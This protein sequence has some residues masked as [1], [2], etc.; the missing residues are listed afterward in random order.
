MMR[1]DADEFSSALRA[2]FPRLHFVSREHWKT[3][4]D[5]DWWH[6]AWRG[7]REREKAG[8][9]TA[10]VRH[11]MRDPRNETPRYWP[12]LGVAEEREFYG[13]VLPESWVAQW[14]EED[15]F[16]VRRVVNAP[17]L[18]FS[19]RRSRFHCR[20]R[21]PGRET[22]WFEDP[23][24]PR[25]DQ[26][27]IVL[28]GGDLSIQWNRY[29]D[30][31]EAFAKTVFRILF[32]QATDRFIHVEFKSRRALMAQPW[33]NRRYGAAGR[34]A[35]AWALARRHNYLYGGQLEKPASYPFAPGEVF[36]AE[37]LAAIKAKW[38]AELDAAI[39]E[40]NRIGKERSTA[41][42]REASRSDK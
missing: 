16:G 29:D 5:W 20:D 23:P 30:E 6:A 37:E 10:Y 4:V 40:Q 34:R 42:R 17:R 13:W 9:P 3:F 22:V 28:E 8:L 39:E 32:K 38:K 15:D 7:H 25:N 19:F 11:R 26:E 27:T 14:G 2:A 18:E 35:E 1:E 31:A 33:R 24:E 12:A 41:I 36:S 21:S